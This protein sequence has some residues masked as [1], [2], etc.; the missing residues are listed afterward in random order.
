MMTCMLMMLII[1]WSWQCCWEALPQ[2]YYICRW[3]VQIM[4]VT[5]MMKITLMMITFN[6]M[7]MVVMMRHGKCWGWQR[8]SWW[9]NVSKEYGDNAS[10]KDHL[11]LTD[12]LSD[13]LWE[14]SH[15]GV[16]HILKKFN[17]TWLMR[18]HDFHSLFIILIRHILSAS[19]Q[20]GD[21]T[22]WSLI[23]FHFLI[24][25][26]LPASCFPHRPSNQSRW[27]RKNWDANK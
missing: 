5:I 6:S 12:G 4:M 13:R 21:E 7:S 24:W 3:L 9:R 11:R 20:Y 26:N 22:S 10:K 14:L 18:H 17:K 8:W 27:K 25:H 16:L 2:R 1:L 19:I 23:H 15:V